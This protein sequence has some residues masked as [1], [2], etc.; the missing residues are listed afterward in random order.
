NAVLDS[1]NFNA[2]MQQ[3]QGARN[4]NAHL[5]QLQTTLLSREASL[6]KEQT[7][8]KSE[9][10]NASGLERALADQSNQFLAVVANRNFAFSQANGPVRALETQIANI[11]NQIAALES[12]AT[13]YGGA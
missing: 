2:A 8:L 3:L 10:A 7:Q 13:V 1:K 4:I 11:D 6:G 9:A 5:G 12:P